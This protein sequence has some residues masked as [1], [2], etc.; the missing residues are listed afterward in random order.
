MGSSYQIVLADDHPLFREGIKR[1]MEAIPDLEVVGEA[2]DG[3]ELLT[4]MQGTTPDMLIL[5]ITMPNLQGI[6]AAQEIK[7][8]YPG[9]K[10]L[11]LTM[12]KSREHLC[13][14]L[15]AGAEGYLLKENAYADLVSAIE[16]IR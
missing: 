2:G 4:L 11:I 6:E 7:R 13:R 9:V 12:H 5:D 15:G 10:I 1:V 14:A 16:T 8:L 3:L